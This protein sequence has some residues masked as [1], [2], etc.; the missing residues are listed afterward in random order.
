MAENRVRL[1]NGQL[2]TAQQ[3]LDHYRSARISGASIPVGDAPGPVPVDMS[4]YMGE[5]P[6]RFYHPGV[7]PIIDQ[8]VKNRNL[9]PGTYD[10]TELA[11]DD[12]SRSAS[13]SNYVTTPWSADYPLRAL[14]FGMKVQRSPAGSL[15]ITMA[16]NGSSK[17]RFGRTKPVS[18]FGLRLTTAS[19]R[20]PARLPGNTMIRKARASDMTSQFTEQDGSTIPLQIRN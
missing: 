15:S 1:T 7:F 16:P 10:T 6:G 17:L 9:A 11:R 5:G 12:K 19:L 13:V 2:W 8:I 3:F 20:R 14:V 18:I 4:W